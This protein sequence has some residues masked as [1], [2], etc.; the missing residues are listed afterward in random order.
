MKRRTR[1]IE[2]EKNAQK[3]LFLN[4]QHSTVKNSNILEDLVSQ[5]QVLGGTISPFKGRGGDVL[6]RHS[7]TIFLEHRMLS[8]RL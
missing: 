6:S 1:G 2:K 7:R 5:I 8:G 3:P 4:Q